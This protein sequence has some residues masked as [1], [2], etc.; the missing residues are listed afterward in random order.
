MHPAGPVRW[1]TK[2]M[3]SQQAPTGHAV[4]VHAPDMKND[5]PKH[6]NIGAMVHAAV[7]A[8]QHAPGQGFG[9]QAPVCQL[10]VQVAWLVIV[11]LL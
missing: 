8:L 5:V 6:W 9:E 1:Q 7:A 10:P 3:E 2:R 4:G 11:Q